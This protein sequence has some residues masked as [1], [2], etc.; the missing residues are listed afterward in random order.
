[1]VSEIMLWSP[2]LRECFNFPVCVGRHYVENKLIYLTK[3]GIGK[4]ELT[5]F[6]YLAFSLFVL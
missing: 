5:F 3:D 6:F 2:L 1:M 4:Q